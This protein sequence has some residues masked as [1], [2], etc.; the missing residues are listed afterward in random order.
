MR[1]ESAEEGQ[2]RLAA[3]YVNGQPVEV[4]SATPTVAEIVRKAGFPPEET[5]AFRL[6]GP[7]DRHGQKLRMDETLSLDSVKGPVYLRCVRRK[8]EDGPSIMPALTSSPADDPRRSLDL[9]DLNPT[10]PGSVPPAQP[11]ETP[12]PGPGLGSTFVP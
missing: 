12:W 11:P 8:K 1:R 4:T 10:A 7:Q 3:V 2:Q 6:R 5:D 9:G